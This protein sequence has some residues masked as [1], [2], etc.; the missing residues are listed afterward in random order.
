MHCLCP[1]GGAFIRYVGKFGRRGQRMSVSIGRVSR[2][3][4]N[5]SRL[6]LFSLADTRTSKTFHILYRSL[7]NFSKLVNIS[8]HISC[9][10]TMRG[11][12]HLKKIKQNWMT[13]EKVRTHNG[14]TVTKDLRKGGKI[15]NREIVC[16]RNKSAVKRALVGI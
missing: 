12:C 10:T 7:Q 8:E 6:F 2:I 13:K 5:I 14:R 3:L 4:S 1:R 15:E 16:V 11:F 9:S